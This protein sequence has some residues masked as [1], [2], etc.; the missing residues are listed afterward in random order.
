[1]DRLPR[2]A[3]HAA[4]LELAHPVSGQWLRFTSPL[5]A[6]FA[7]ALDALQAFIESPRG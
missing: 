4:E 2:Q 5:P 3:L 6:D 7:G 1:L